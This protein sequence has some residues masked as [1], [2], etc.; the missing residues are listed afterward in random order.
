M[1]KQPVE[2]KKDTEMAD[3]AI[4]TTSTAVEMVDAQTEVSTETTES[5]TETMEMENLVISPVE[6][7][8][9]VS[10]ESKEVVKKTEQP[11]KKKAK[12][13]HN[14]KDGGSGYAKFASGALAGVVI[15]SI[16]MFAALVATAPV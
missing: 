5:A 3:V 11:K 10:V 12:R 2:E 13:S 1:L 14:D 8:E 15:G 7:N 16:G 6:Q 9:T 4:Q